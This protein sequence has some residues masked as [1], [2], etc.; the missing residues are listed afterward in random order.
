[1]KST[2]VKSKDDRQNDVEDENETCDIQP[3]HPFVCLSIENETFMNL[4]LAIQLWKE[5]SDSNWKT[6]SQIV[7]EKNVLDIIQATAEI[8]A[9]ASRVSN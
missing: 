8:Y 3:A 9:T 7:I 1:M 5:I 6:L 4:D 2:S